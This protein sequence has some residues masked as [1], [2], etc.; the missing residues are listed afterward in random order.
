MNGHLGCFHVLATV[1]IS[2]MNT[3]VNVSFRIVA[4]SEH[5][6]GSGTAGHMID[7]FPGF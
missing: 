2:A 3:G 7:L 5:R 6:P 1:S 4:F